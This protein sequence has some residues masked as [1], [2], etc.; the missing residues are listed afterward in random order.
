MKIVIIAAMPRELAALSASWPTETIAR[1]GRKFCVATTTEAI[2]VTAGMG[3]ENAARGLEL[4]LERTAISTVVSAGFAGALDPALKVG[5]VLQASTVIDAATGER[6]ATA[7]GDGSSLVTISSVADAAEKRRLREAY[8]AH[9]ADMEA[10]AL[11]R[12]CAARSLPFF[13]IKSISDA[14]TFS[15]PVLGRFATAQGQFRTAAF[16]LH[17]ALRPALWAKVRELAKGASA[18]QS[19]LARALRAFLNEHGHLS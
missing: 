16:A 4:A 14:A 15:L 9:L 12:I 2:A 19:G 13:A 5:D 1:N 6:F 7:Q 3:P 11:A 8:S 17:V 18:A 10:A